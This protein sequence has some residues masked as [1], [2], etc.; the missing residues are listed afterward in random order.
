M[1]V[2]GLDAFHEQ[3]FHVLLTRNGLSLDHLRQGSFFTR[4]GKEH[5]PGTTSYG[6]ARELMRLILRNEA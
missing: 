3:T 2:S 1:G 4:H 5:V 6:T